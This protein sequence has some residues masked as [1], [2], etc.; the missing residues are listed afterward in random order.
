M[1][2]EDENAKGYIVHN[3]IYMTVSKRLT[4]GEKT[5][6]AVARDWGREKD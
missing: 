5:S 6:W 3:S 2:T 4:L 1:L